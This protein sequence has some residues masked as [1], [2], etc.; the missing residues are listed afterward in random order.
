MGDTIQLGGGVQINVHT[1][2]ELVNGTPVLIVPHTHTDRE[3][4]ISLGTGF[5]SWDHLLTEIEYVAVSEA[6]S[7]HIPDEAA[8]ALAD[9]EFE[10][11]DVFTLAATAEPGAPEAD[12]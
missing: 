1:D 2:E 6:A 8:S 3:A 12:G 9:A 10:A 4:P 5:E 11:I 7:S